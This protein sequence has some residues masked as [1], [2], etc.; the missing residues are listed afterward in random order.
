[1]QM[2]VSGWF[3]PTSSAGIKDQDTHNYIVTCE[4]IDG[5]W[6]D[7]VHV[8]SSGFD[9]SLFHD[10]DSHKWFVN[11]RWTH[12]APGTGCNPA[13]HLFDGILLQEWSPERGLFGPVTNIYCGT[14]L[15]L[16]EGPHLLQ[17]QWLVLSDRRRR[18]H[19]L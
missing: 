10:D 1:M 16:T 15:G 14:P 13:H 3:T 11:M 2:A 7:P 12:R 18:R 9:P 5:V 19:R 17:A 8:N 6:S 4:T